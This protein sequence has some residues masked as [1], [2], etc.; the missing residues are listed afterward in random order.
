M[1]TAGPTAPVVTMTD[2]YSASFIGPLHHY[3]ESQSG[4]RRVPGHARTLFIGHCG[5]YPPF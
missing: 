5:A 1:V 3:T 2:T 4:H